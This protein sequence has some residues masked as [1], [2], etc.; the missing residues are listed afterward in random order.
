LNLFGRSFD[1]DFIARSRLRFSL[2]IGIIGYAISALNILTFA[3]VW[4]STFDYY[5]VPIM[6]MYTVFPIGFVFACWY[7]GYIYDTKGYWGKENSHVNLKM[8]P[9]FE[10]I[11]S[12]VSDSRRDIAIIKKMLE[13][14]NATKQ[15]E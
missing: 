6:L 3:K 4:Q 10:E 14:R 8:N 2:G 15:N 12:G 13:E 9:E 11:R 5:G 1:G 7:I